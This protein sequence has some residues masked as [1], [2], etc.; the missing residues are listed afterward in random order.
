MPFSNP[1]AN[2]LVLFVGALAIGA[3]ILLGFV[4]FL[5]LG[6]LLLVLAAIVG[7]RLWWFNR[8]L[9][10]DGHAG[11]GSGNAGATVNVEVIE[12]EYR[13]VQTNGRPDGS[14]ET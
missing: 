13:I 14:G 2:A 5:A 3:S 9:R 10:R 12:G 6:S 8:K 7:I 11:P 4:V 1:L